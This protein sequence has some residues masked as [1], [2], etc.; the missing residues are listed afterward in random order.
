MK[1]I[2]KTMLRTCAGFAAAAALVVGGAGMA[3]AA[4]TSPAHTHFGPFGCQP[5]DREQ[6]NV[7][8]TNSVKVPWNGG[9]LTYTVTFKQVGN[10]L[11]GTLTDPYYGS[12]GTTGPIFGT[13][14]GSNISFSFTY[15]S[16]SIQG[17]R[18]FTG[19]INWWGYVINGNWSETGSEKASGNWSLGS[20]VRHACPPWYR[21][22]AACP[23]YPY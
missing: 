21:P 20:K 4:T 10:C 11:T 1:S 13:V 23:V 12:S 15:P 3:S 5:W 9:T 18:T 6:W 8:G 2:S 22:G 16:G 14:N 19:T 7:N 17:T